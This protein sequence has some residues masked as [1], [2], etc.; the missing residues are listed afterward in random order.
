MEILLLAVVLT[1]ITMQIIPVCDLDYCPSSVDA[2]NDTFILMA[3]ATIHTSKVYGVSKIVTQITTT[4]ISAEDIRF[5]VFWECEC[6]ADA[7]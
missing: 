2:A 6:C 7:Q 1:V 4:L 5:L 3:L